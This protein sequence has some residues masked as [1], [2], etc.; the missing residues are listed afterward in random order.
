MSTEI[1]DLA[2]AAAGGDAAALDDLL[3]LVRPDVLRLCA[4]FLPHREDAEEACQDTL[5]ALARGIGGFEGRSS[6]R[7]WLHRL[8]ANRA[9][10]T[11]QALRRRADREAA[12]LTLPDRADPRRTS[13]V[14][15]TRL[16]LLDALD[17]LGPELAEAVALRDVLGL[18]YRE[19]AALQE[20]PE[21][22]V[23]SRIHDARRRLRERLD[24]GLP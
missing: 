17:R 5:L 18:S 6:V 2:R 1:D 20:V 24:G 9:R 11:Y 12:V 4:R 15:G 7:T 23:K 19:I 14:A 3:V 10:S 21:G 16:D 22:T 8:A 13:V